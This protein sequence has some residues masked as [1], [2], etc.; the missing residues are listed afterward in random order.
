MFDLNYPQFGVIQI[1]ESSVKIYKD[2]Y[3]SMVVHVGKPVMSAIWS[4]GALNIH[5]LDGT[6]RRYSGPYS[7]IEVR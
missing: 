7:F 3:C 6:I 4:N 2:M 5:L 1:L